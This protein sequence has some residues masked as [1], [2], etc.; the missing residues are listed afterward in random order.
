M[1]KAFRTVPV[2]LILLGLALP[3]WGEVQPAPAVSSAAVCSAPAAAL[4]WLAPPP[5]FR[6]TGCGTCSDTPCNGLPLGAT[7]ATSG[8]C[9]GIFVG[10][11]PRTCS[12]GS[13]YQC[14]CDLGQ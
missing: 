6:T 9:I 12:D 1:R 14:L 2:L 3:V 4:P 5:L 13:G 10:G 11:H 8:T 7:C